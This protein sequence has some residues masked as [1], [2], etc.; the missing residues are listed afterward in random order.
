GGI[1]FLLGRWMP[2]RYISFVAKK[3][4]MGQAEAVVV[5]NEWGQMTTEP[6]STKYYGGPV[7]SVFSPEQMEK[8]IDD[9][10][11]G[12]EDAA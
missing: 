7:N 3:C 4:S 11:E 8:E 2:H 5:E 12:Y 6:I 10:D 1:V 9:D